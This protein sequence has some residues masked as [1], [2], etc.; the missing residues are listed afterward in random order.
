[1]FLQHR[2]DL[3]GDNHLRPR[4]HYSFWHGDTSSFVLRNDYLQSWHIEYGTWKTD[5]RDVINDGTTYIASWQSCK[6]YNATDF[7]GKII[8]FNSRYKNTMIRTDCFCE[9]MLQL[10]NNPII[11]LSREEY[12]SI[13]H[14]KKS[15]ELLN[16]NEGCSESYDFVAQHAISAILY[17]LYNAVCEGKKSLPTI[18]RA[19]KENFL[20]SSSNFCYQTISS[21]GVWFSTRRKC[22]WLLAIFR[23]L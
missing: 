15:I 17:I 9:L 4:L 21:N 5:L 22:A 11:K 12:G 14:I 2:N 23:E 8:L 13:V 19:D 10:A 16:S 3:H 18:F 20:G 1:M 6:L 7:K